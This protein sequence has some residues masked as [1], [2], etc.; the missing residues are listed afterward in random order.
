MKKNHKILHPVGNFKIFLI[1]KIAFYL[2]SILIFF[3]SFLIKIKKSES[4]IIISNA[5]YA[6]WKKDK[7]FKKFII[8]SINLLSLMKEDFIHCG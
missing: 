7:K 4:E 5:T 8:K 3:L 6:P 1:K 2:N